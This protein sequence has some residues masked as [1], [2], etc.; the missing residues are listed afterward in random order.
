MRTIFFDMDGTLADLYGVP[1]WLEKLQATD[2][3]PYRDAAVMHNMN[4]LAR[5]LNKLQKLGYQIGIISWLAKNS[6]DEYDI[7]VENEKRSWLKLHLHSVHFDVIYIKEYGFPKESFATDNDILFDDE[8]R[9]REHWCGEA[10]EPNM[11]FEILKELVSE[12]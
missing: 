8:Q 5:Y 1:N 11:I 2:A 10:Y 6:T 4:L 3:S 9:N 7:A 12:S